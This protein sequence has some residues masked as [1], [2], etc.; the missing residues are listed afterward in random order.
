MG[1]VVNTNIASINAQRQL[2]SSGADLDQAS[3]RLASG[4]R[5]NSAADD[6]AGLAIA[7]R[8]TSQIRGLDQAIRNA[9]DGISLIQTAE[10][11]LDATTN[12]LQRV[13]ELSVQSA[14]GI[15]SDT[16]RATLD[17][18]V[19][20]LTSELDRI[21]GSTS[22]NGQ[23]I[24]D[25]SLGTLTL[26]VGAETGDTIAI[27]VQGFSASELGGAAGGGDVVGAAASG[28]LITALNV[29]DGAAATQSMNINGQNVGDLSTASTLED[30]LAIINSSVSGV[31]TSAF[32][33][34]TFGT[35]SA[36]GNG[37]LT[38][39]NRLD[40]TVLGQD[41]ATTAVQIGNT[42]SVQEIADKLN[43]Q[44]GSLLQASVNDEGRLELNS[45]LAT[46]ITVADS[47]GTGTGDASTALGT[48]SGSAA[49]SLEARLSFE[50]TSGE[51]GLVPSASVGGT[52]TV[53]SVDISFTSTTTNATAG[54]IAAIG[55]QA[56]TAGDVTGG[57][58]SAGALM[59]G[60]LV[61][62]GVEIGPVAGGAANAT[63][64]GDAL[65][66]A[67]NL[68]SASTG[69]V[70]S[71]ASGAL[72]LD[73]V[74]SSE[75][76]VEFG[77]A[78]AATTATFTG[79]IETNSSN[80]QGGSVADIDISSQAGATAA[81]EVV[82]LALEQINS[83]RADLG[84]VNNRLDFT[85]SNLSNVS[86]NTS[87]A[88]SRIMDADFASETAE[89]SRAQVLQQASQAILAQANARPQQ[90]LSLLN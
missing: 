20:Q 3:E 62:N 55:V 72:T 6:A 45:T 14:N 68:Q 8:Q 58:A 22:F 69:V 27:D 26:Q 56:R 29:I 38:G 37:I 7:N 46:T 90:V 61:I 34:G 83:Q 71:N 57:A 63:A 12:I 11:A 66:T 40:F 44:A 79:L 80:S 75:I 32:V 52:P 33:E 53:N 35:A 24:L 25:G 77:E 59:A 67:I 13:R 65:V 1:L 4:K 31:E 36:S 39:D 51:P 15:Y 81:I 10:G 88:R 76:S 43:E 84:A 85:V 19:E 30:Q 73:S 50:I 5:I 47:V 28:S 49:A 41:G 16:D 48:T 9:N 23:N 60:D 2:S 64:Q 17:A 42:G 70:A 21:A 78:N 89:L 54:E 74:D 82:D 87:A 18:E 86:E